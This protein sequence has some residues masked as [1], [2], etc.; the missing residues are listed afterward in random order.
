P[1][2]GFFCPPT[3]T[4]Y[5]SQDLPIVEDHYVECGPNPRLASG[6]SHFVQQGQYPCITLETQGLN[7][8]AALPYHVG[9]ES[10]DGIH[11][12]LT[13]QAAHRRTDGTQHF[14]FAPT[15]LASGV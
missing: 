5:S 7:S 14:R 1:G 4:N 9:E 15:T 11:V 8:A 3:E 2:Y 12:F 10:N 6:T 13:K